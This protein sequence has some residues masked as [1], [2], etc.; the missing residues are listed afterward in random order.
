[1]STGK[2]V[3]IALAVVAIIG[4]AASRAIAGNSDRGVE[5]QTE[6]V[7]LQ[8]LISTVTTSGNIRAGRTVDISADVSGRVVELNVAEGANVEAGAVLLRIDPTQFQAA[9]ARARASVSQAG[10]QVEQQEASRMR[11]KREFDRLDGLAAADSALVSGQ[12]L[13]NARS[14]LEVADRQLESLGFGVAQAQAALDE[15][16]ETLAKT[17]I[18]APMSGTVTRLNIEQGETAVVGTMNNPGSLLLTISELSTVEAVVQI[19]ETDVPKISFG[20]SAVVELDAY[21]GRTMAGRV[22]EIGNSAIQSP[23]SA[24]ASGQTVSIDFEVVITLDD[25]IGGIRPDL[26]ATADIVTAVRRDVV[27]IPIISLTV[28]ES[29]GSVP[30]SD[31]TT[32]E[33]APE[34]RQPGPATRQAP[35]DVEGVF[36]VREG[37]AVF[38]PVTV[39]ITG[40]EYFEVIEGVEVGETIISGPYQRI[41][42]LTEGDRVRTDD[43]QGNS[44]S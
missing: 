26:S 38:V 10:S 43:A 17:I 24:A 21:P 20:D 15:A 40:L 22:T 6:T 29:D 23:E 36:L 30:A 11:A 1:M 28:R 41:R 4:I 34:E 9:V 12:E 19:D 2:K 25:P 16:N 5:V 37:R 35:S 32:D 44:E 31:D 14:D 3:L 13:D 7:S 42:Q 18:R 8:T 27:A 39:G 33:D